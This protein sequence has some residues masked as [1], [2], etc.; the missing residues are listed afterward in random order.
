VSTESIGQ[1]LR[2]ARMRA[3]IPLE[4]ASERTKIKV[5]VLEALEAG[6][7][8]QVPGG[9]VYVRNFLR[10]Y[11]RFL[12]IDADGLVA[13]FDAARPQAAQP[14][15]IIS[16][17]PAVVRWSEA[18]PAFTRRRKSRARLWGAGAVV[19][20][21]A[22]VAVGLVAWLGGAPGA[23]ELAQGPPVVEPVGGREGLPSGTEVQTPAGGSSEV[24]ATE[25][26]PASPAALPEPAPEAPGATTLAFEPLEVRTVVHQRSW[27]RVDV[28]G[29]TV[30]TGIL[31]A[32]EEATWTGDD[33]IRIR[34]G[35]AQGV[36]VFLNGHDL[37]RAGEDVVTRTYTRATLAE[38]EGRR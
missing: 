38:L 6:A 31:E 37:G 17:G 24:A 2:E 12:K 27:M 26:P 15:Q 5:R 19:V 7:F 23:G 21:L 20:L 16:E 22:A 36:Q 14:A 8:D 29:T 4:E 13:E 32:G 35:Y 9:D 28:D 33:E 30:Y 25:T 11:A 34:F 10:S 1:K 18:P 3:G